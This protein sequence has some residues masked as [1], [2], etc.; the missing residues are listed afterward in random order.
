VPRLTVRG[1]GD[2]T[3]AVVGGRVLAEVPAGK[4]KSTG[5]D[6]EENLHRHISR[7]R[8]SLFSSPSS[9][10]SLERA[11]DQFGVAAST[12]LEH[13]GSLGNLGLLVGEGSAEG[14]SRS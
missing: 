14:R 10:V 6:G 1:L 3:L 13:L 2:A 4:R 11:H 7:V 12:L 9:I 5:H 8:R